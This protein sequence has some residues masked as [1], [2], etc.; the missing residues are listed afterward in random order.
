M[1]NKA[2]SS[3]PGGREPAPGRLSI[4]QAFLNSVDL[5]GNTEAFDTTRGLQDWIV[6]HH[7]GGSELRISE[8]DRDRA[9]LLRE[10]LRDLLAAHNDDPVPDDARDRVDGVLRGVSLAVGFAGDSPDLRSTASGIDGVFGQLAAIIH[11]S[12]ID[13][14]WQRLKTCRNDAC[15]WAFYDASKNHSGAWCSM[16]ICGSRH[17]ARTYRGR[18]APPA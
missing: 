9:I 11:T 10:G 7:L 14:T 1:T 13:G 16:A 17:K 15:R 2:I 5:E 18:Q 3:E 12:S 4:V 8:S 6:T